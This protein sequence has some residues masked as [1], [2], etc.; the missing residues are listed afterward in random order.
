MDESSER[1]RPT[2]ETNPLVEKLGKHKLRALAAIGIVA[3]GLFGISGKANAGAGVSVEAYNP[4]TGRN[5]AGV[6]TVEST[7][8]GG[9]QS[10]GIS[11][12]VSGRVSGRGELFTVSIGGASFNV[13]YTELKGDKG[14]GS[15]VL[16]AIHPAADTLK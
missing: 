14:E 4:F 1:L 6:V 10:L 3:S 15:T 5:V 2:R 16:L 11:P 13:G 7:E 12:R 9:W 8:K